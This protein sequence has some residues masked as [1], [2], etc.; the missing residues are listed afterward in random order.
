MKKQFESPKT[1]KMI[2]IAL[3]VLAVVLIVPIVMLGF[4]AKPQADDYDFSLIAREMLRGSEAGWFKS[5]F[6]YIGAAFKTMAHFYKTWQGTFT[7]SFCNALN[8]IV[9][10]EKLAGITPLIYILLV[11]LAINYIIH[12][13]NRN[14]IHKGLL[15]QLSIAAALTTALFIWMPSLN[16]GLY[17]YCGASC[18]T[19]WMVAVFCIPA[20]VMD[21]YYSSGRRRNTD[22]IFSS[23]LGFL[24]GGTNQAVA[25]ELILLLLAASIYLVLIKR[26]YYS[27]I[28]L[29]FSVFGFLLSA[30]APGTR[31]RQGSFEQLSPLRTII[32]TIIKVRE[33]SG[34]CITLMYLV[35]FLLITPFAL[36][37]VTNVRVRLPKRFPIIEILTGLMIICGMWCVP[38]MATQTF[39]SPRFENAVWVSFMITSWTNYVMIL[40]WI[41]NKG[42]LNPEK[43][44]GAKDYQLIRFIVMAGSLCVLFI[45]V[46]NDYESNSLRAYHELRNGK[47]KAYS[48]EMDKRIETITDSDEELV[49]IDPVVNRD[50]MLYFSDIY[51]FPDEW[52]NATMGRYY[53]KKIGLTYDPYLEPPQED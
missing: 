35:S 24:I 53:G 32:D 47:A 4:Y 40:G 7:C 42:W 23:I 8:P 37:I 20:S 22:I 12:V 41:T 16:E 13:I 49:L 51:I 25:F 21:A 31:I 9:F 28:P 43:I 46:Q 30:L 39:G 18:Y 52:P 26:K 19:F 3:I 34:S 2:S 50:S 15:W 33:D 11:F 14:H 1:E 29:V 36:E 5:F 17:W 45:G 6:I 27:F 44:C 10:N 38:Y 48:E